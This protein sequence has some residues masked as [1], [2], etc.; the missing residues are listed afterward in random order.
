M[1]QLALAALYLAAALGANPAGAGEIADTL[2]TGEMKKL[3]VADGGPVP[4]AV[5]LDETDTG[6][7]LAKY[8]GKVVLLNF[9]ATWCAPCRE[10][11]PHLDA[12][13]GEAG[14]EDFAVVAVATGRNPLPAIER[15]FAGNGITRLP[16]LRD[17]GQELSAAMGVFGLPVT[18][19]LDREGRE[20]ARMTGEA[21]WSSPEA[22]AVIA[23]L[24][25]D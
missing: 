17:P 10:E 1:R 14:G 22:L 16:I 24:V 25:A 13:Q 23:A 6:Q 5:L 20:V 3:V 11:M 4:D 15:F 8:R 7:S 19:L 2:L 12:L 18:V 9:W 21:D